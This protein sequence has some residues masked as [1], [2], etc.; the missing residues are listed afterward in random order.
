MA[1]LDTHR[2]R[3]PIPT[4]GATYI[5][6]KLSVN[7][8]RDNASILNTSAFNLNNAVFNL[9]NETDL[10]IN[11]NNRVNAAA[12][13]TMNAST[14]TLTGGWPTLTPRRLF[15]ALNDQFGGRTPLP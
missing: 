13:V 5:Y 2:G 7:P 14:I 10:F 1:E 15:G 11:N 3:R 9:N 6:G 12:P 4:T 8:G